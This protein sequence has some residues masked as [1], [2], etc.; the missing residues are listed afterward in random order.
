MRALTRASLASGIAVL[1]RQDPDLAGVIARLGPPEFWSRPPGFQ[2]LVYIVFEQQ[3]SLA[4]ART[5]FERVA[6]LL[7][8][9]SPEAY[10][11]LSSDD[12]RSAGVSRQK[13]RYTTLIAEAVIDGV[14]PLARLGRYDDE[15]V[16]QRLTSI[17][18]IGNWTADIYLMVALRRPD[19]W[20]VGD[21]ALRKALQSLKGVDAQADAEQLI[22]A[23]NDYRPY[24]SIATRI[25]WRHYLHELQR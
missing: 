14:L 8:D 18:G 13:I 19:L 17:T 15:R 21:L 7:P 1:S 3:V 4:S 10:L 25:L 23:G 5:T 11:K 6:R 20:P 16:R 22:A 9:F 24:R 12:L 2:T